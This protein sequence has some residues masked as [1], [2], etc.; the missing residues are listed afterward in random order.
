MGCGSSIDLFS[1]QYIVCDAK[2][3]E[4]EEIKKSMVDFDI[5]N[6]DK[7]QRQLAKMTELEKNLRS[8]L[9]PK[10][11]DYLNSQKRDPSS[12]NIDV[13]IKKYDDLIDRFHKAQSANERISIDMKAENQQIA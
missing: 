9:M 5:N 2:V 6:P 7:F 1:K 3:K 10:L 13:K 12:K 4:L 8:N 11:E